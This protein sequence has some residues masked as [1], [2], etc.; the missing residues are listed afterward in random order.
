M[1]SKILDIL[2]EILHVQREISADLKILLPLLT[3]EK[4]VFLDNTDAKRLL[5]ISDSTLYRLCKTNQ[6]N[7]Q[8]IGNKRYYL[9]SDL[10]KWMRKSRQN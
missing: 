1:L 10:L 9:K 3:E 8:M 5:K 2:E 6:I 7:F 4:D